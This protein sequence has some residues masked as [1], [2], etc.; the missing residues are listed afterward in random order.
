MTSPMIEL[1]TVCTGNI[2][3]SPLAAVALQHR[4]TASGVASNVRSAGTQGLTSVPMTPEAQ[5][6]AVAAGVPEAD[7]A[8][9][10]SR[11]LTEGMLNS[12]DLILA[13]TRE[14]RTRTV[15]L[16][17]SAMHRTFTTREL[18]RVSASLDDDALRSACAGSTPSERLRAMVRYVSQHRSLFP[19]AS[20][21]DDDVIDPYRKGWAVYELSAAQLLPTL[22]AVER[23][24]RIAN[25]SSSVA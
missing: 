21:S 9:H 20:P 22:A 17:P 8:A 10:R 14:H 6:L 7:A 11:A 23:L 16:R 24:A 2:C 3:R 4:L 19:A 5:R 12:P 15:S 1:L 18:A 25:E 13:M